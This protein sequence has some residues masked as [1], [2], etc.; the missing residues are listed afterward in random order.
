MRKL[1]IVIAMTSLVGSLLAIQS[2]RV[3]DRPSN[4]TELPN[5]FE[6]PAQRPEVPQVIAPRV[7]RFQK[8]VSIAER[9]D[10]SE[11]TVLLVKLDAPPALAKSDEMTTFEFLTRLADAVA[12]VRVLSVTGM[13]N[14]SRD[15]V[16]SSIEVEC[17][18][19]LK[20]L[21]DSQPASGQRLVF[22]EQDGEARV[23]TTRVVAQRRWAV[24]ME[25]GNRYLVFMQS[26]P[27][28]TF[29]TFGSEGSYLLHDESLTRLVRLEHG[30]SSESSVSA[31]AARQ[32]IAR[33]AALPTIK[34]VRV[35]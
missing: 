25:E 33:A 35:R 12:I 26:T 31:S 16:T 14:E 30:A 18:E 32:E 24:A 1:A 27:D 34:P 3:W 9:L 20:S 5:L 11:D 7:L 2:G 28:G 13:L 6:V 4:Q 19:V 15:W 10:P 23:G 21:D 29:Q 8:G 22:R 17:D